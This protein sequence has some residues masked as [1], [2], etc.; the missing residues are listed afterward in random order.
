MLLQ[1]TMNWMTYKQKTFISHSARREKVQDEG[2]ANSVSSED[3]PPSS[4]TALFSLGLHVV[5]EGVGSP[6]GLFYKGANTRMT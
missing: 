1:D 4:H 6:W 2:T 5:E 3:P